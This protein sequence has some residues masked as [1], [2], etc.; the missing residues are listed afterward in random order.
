[1]SSI[2]MGGEPPAVVP[3]VVGVDGALNAGR[4]THP[5]SRVV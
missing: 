5:G 1:M 4:A 2:D 3:L